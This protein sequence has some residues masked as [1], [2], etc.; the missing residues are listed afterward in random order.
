MVITNYFAL[1]WKNKILRNWV[2]FAVLGFICSII[3]YLQF[4]SH[5]PHPPGADR[6]VFCT[7]CNAKYTKRIL[8]IN[9][10]NDANNFCPKCN[11]KLE[12]G[13]KCQD[14]DFEFPLRK[15]ILPVEKLKTMDKF[16]AVTA[17]RKC[18]NCDSEKT[19]PLSVAKKKKSTK[20]E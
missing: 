14:C 2:I 16:R 4:F 13:W 9:D 7:S 6:I 19:F 11:K 18:P 17:M 8:D 12:Y 1:F 15:N 5:T 10:M 20:S 3:L